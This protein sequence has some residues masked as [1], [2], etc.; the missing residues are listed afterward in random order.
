MPNKIP[1][2]K[3]IAHAGFCSR[4]KAEQFIRAKQVFVNGKTAE[5]GA[6]VEETD[7]VIIHGQKLNLATENIYIIL[8]KPS[9]FT[10]TNRSFSDEKN[11]FSLLPQSITSK[12]KLHIAG[13]LDKNSRGLVLLTNDGDLTKRLTHP[14]FEHKKVYEV[15][16]NKITAGKEKEILN[17]LRNGI[18][19]GEGDGRVMAKEAEYLGNKKF[20][21]TLITGKKRQIRRMFS[22]LGLKVTDLLRIKLAEIELNGLKEGDYKKIKKPTDT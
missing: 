1:L 17:K 15:R 7:E 2:T 13:R 18:N 5:L 11:I 12:Y 6:M 19:I 14:K 22:V 20:K 21:I 10:C 9:G 16:L 3:Y 8:N 4:R